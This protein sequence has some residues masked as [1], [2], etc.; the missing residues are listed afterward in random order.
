[1][2]FDLLS[3][4]FPHPRDCS[5]LLELGAPVSSFLVHLTNALVLFS[6]TSLDVSFLLPFQASVSPPFLGSN[7]LLV[8]PF[9]ISAFFPFLLISSFL[10]SFHTC[11]LVP[12]SF[13]PSSAF[14][15]TLISFLTSSLFF[16][17][18]SFFLFFF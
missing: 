14:R 8:R 2:N 1:M 18:F 11:V 4:F 5:F 10:H 6:I 16:F 13:S 15:P 9:L 7:S 3:Y 12:P 17:F